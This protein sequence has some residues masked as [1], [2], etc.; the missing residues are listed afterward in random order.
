MATRG[1]S[2]GSKNRSASRQAVSARDARTA[3][4]DGIESVRSSILNGGFAAQRNSNLRMKNIKSA[5]K[6]VIGLDYGTT[7]TSVSYSIVPINSGNIKGSANDVMSVISWPMDGEDGERRQVPTESWYSS[8][9]IERHLDDA[10]KIL[11][12]NLF[13]SFK[14]QHPL[15]LCGTGGDTTHDPEDSEMEDELFVDFLWGYGVP[16]QIYK[17]NSTRSQRRLVKRAKL[18]LVETEYTNEDR[19]GLRGT[20]TSLL[21]EGLIRRHGRRSKTESD[22]WDAVDPISDY[23][24]K[25]L[26]HTKEQLKFLHGFTDQTPVDFVMTVP[27]VWS[28]EASRV[29]QTSVKAAIQATALGR[30]G[31]TTA[32]N[33][34][35]IS[36]PEAAATFL[37]ENSEDISLGETFIIAD[38]GGGTVDVVTYGVGNRYPLRLKGERIQPIGGSSQNISLDNFVKL[39]CVLGDN[40]GSS[41]LNDRYK[42]MLFN[43]LQDEDYLLKNGETLEAIVNRLIPDFENEYK[44]R[45]N[46]MNRVG[47]RVYIAGLRS[48]E[49]MNRVG[50]A[51]KRFETNN[52]LMNKSD[53]EEIFGPLLKRISALLENQIKQ[54][55]AK[56]LVVKKVFLVG[57]FGASP[58]L[59]SYLK[60][61]LR[62][63]SE[64]VN[65]NIEL[66]ADKRKCITAVASGAVFRALDKK[67]GPERIS[68]SSYGLLRLEPWEPRMYPG[69]GGAKPPETSELDGE[70]YVPTIDYFM[71]KGKPVR[72]NHQFEPFLTYHT[73][74]IDEQQFLCEELLYV[75]DTA[76]ESHYSRKSIKNA[77]AQIAGRI[78]VDMTFL[79]ERGIIKPVDPD[80]GKKGV[81]H[82]KVEFELVAIVEGRALRYEARYPAGE[83]GKV[84]G[85]GQFCIAA[86]FKE[87]TD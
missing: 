37:L 69:H 80:D 23:L 32:D 14:G 42:D 81:K 53:Y 28:P 72:S 33:I 76:T 4:N 48:D 70:R 86:A 29:L 36:E 58:S 26:Q 79:R 21:K 40:C 77:D 3:Q 67:N 10:D 22:M 52:L 56:G 17:A 60:Q 13:D 68:Q 11:D 25:V 65:F 62:E 5:E 24:V 51:E 57:G 66:V 9:P 31:G 2:F 63:K 15:T 30:P 55:V 12:Q 18:M 6:V 54:A 1:N 41:Y 8:E 19:K 84:L 71:I 75:S 85:K 82:Y 27:T 83:D 59:K 64:Q 39:I 44:R 43:R 35:F 49:Q 78:I 74:A 61:W 38:C 46:V 34:F 50:L 7:F 87:G 73:F 16:Y 20:F 47:H 45:V